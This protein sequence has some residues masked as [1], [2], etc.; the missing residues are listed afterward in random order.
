MAYYLFVT[1]GFILTLGILGC[2]FVYSL[3]LGLKSE[4]AKKVDPK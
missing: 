4:D 1:V 3:K 2:A